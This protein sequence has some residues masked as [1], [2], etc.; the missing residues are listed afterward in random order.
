M[1]IYFPKSRRKT[2]SGKNQE[3][4]ETKLTYSTWEGRKKN[5]KIIFFFITREIFLYQTYANMK[6]H[7][8]RAKNAQNF[9]L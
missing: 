2:V 6:E 4:K 1:K 8:R 9:Q 7:K 3:E 5:I